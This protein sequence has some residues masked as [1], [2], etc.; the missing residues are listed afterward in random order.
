[1]HETGANQVPDALGIVHDARDQ[2]PSLRRIE[3]ADGQVHDARLHPFAHVG[4]RA[5]RGDSE[6]LTER[7]RGHRLHE[8]RRPRS[9]RDR[10]QQLRSAA[11][12]D[13]VNEVFGRGWQHQ[14]GEPADQHQPQTEQQPPAMGPDQRARLAPCGRE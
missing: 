3:I 5:L 14:A 9:Q 1:L 8:R 6:D 12:H 2:H 11:I 10:H 13:V 4:D 7:K